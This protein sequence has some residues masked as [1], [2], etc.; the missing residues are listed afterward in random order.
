MKDKGQDALFRSEPSRKRQIIL[1]GE[2]I[3]SDYRLLG[4]DENA[5]T[6]ALGHCLSLDDAFLAAFLRQ[7]DFRGIKSTQVR[8][9]IIGLQAHQIEQG[10]TDLEIHI[11]K[12]LHLII[13]AKVGGQFPKRE[14]VEKYVKRLRYQGSRGK[15]MVLT[16]DPNDRMESNLRAEFPK[17]VGFRTWNEVLELAQEHAANEDEHAFSAVRAFADFMKEV[18]GMSIYAPDV[19]MVPLAT[20]KWKATSKGESV[21]D[22]HVKHRF[23]VTDDRSHR[24]SR[25]MGFRFDG[26]LQYIGRIKEIKRDVKSSEISPYATEF[27][28]RERLWEVVRLEELVKFPY[29]IAIG[30]P[31]STLCL[32]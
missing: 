27:W 10:I 22:L 24:P 21:A 31:P 5:L 6:L 8:N 29:H 30:K 3:S 14:Q 20:K 7:C 13:E 2:A 23:W 12:R 1:H 17:R 9:A 28:S 32:L 4:S 25:Y 19:F 15:V 26:R 18:Y 11:P 16:R